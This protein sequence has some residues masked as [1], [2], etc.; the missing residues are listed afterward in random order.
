MLEENNED[1]N[2]KTITLEVV[3]ADGLDIAI[4][5]FKIGNDDEDIIRGE[6]VDIMIN[7]KNI[8]NVSLTEST[9]INTQ[10]IFHNFD[11]FTET[12]IIYE[13]YP[14]INNPLNLDEIFTYTHNGK[15]LTSG[16]KTISYKIDTGDDLNESNELNNNIEKT[17]YVYAT[18]EEADQFKIL[19][20]TYDTISSSSIRVKW[21]SDKN[22]NVEV[23]YNRDI[24]TTFDIYKITPRID[25]WPKTETASTSSIIIVENLTPSEGYIFKTRGYQNDAEEYSEIYNFIMPANDTIQ[26]TSLINKNIDSNASTTKITWSTNMLSSGYV[27]YKLTTSENYLNSGIGEQSIE[28]QILISNLEPGNYEYYVESESGEDAYK[29]ELGYFTI[30]EK[31]VGMTDNEEEVEGEEEDEDNEN[32][33]DNQSSTTDTVSDDTNNKINNKVM[34]SRLKGKIMLKVEDLG[35]AYYINADSDTMHY[36]GKPADAYQVMR[37]QGIGITNNDLAKIPIGFGSLTGPDL[38]EDGLPDLL[39]DAIGTDKNKADT[40]SDGHNDQLEIINGYSPTQIGDA[41]LSLNTSFAKLQAG[42][43]FLQIET[44]GEA[45]YINP[46]D[47]KRYFLG[48]ANDAFQV[49]RNLGLGISNNDF[50][51]MR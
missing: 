14:T 3:S 41:K 24:Y 20:V 42:R 7:I 25:E 32:D 1:N 51:N 26:L 47:S 9:G 30:D 22:A 23:M 38:D 27:Y 44:H 31:N 8:G 37:E 21:T 45:W 34:Y 49:M 33:T 15:Y 43:I 36:L 35:K 17:F 19:N 40:D 50:N 4:D 48:R 12:N 13:N 16:N 18:Q 11:G 10:N 5:S 29:S 39:E 2:Q 28:H 46:T 6:D